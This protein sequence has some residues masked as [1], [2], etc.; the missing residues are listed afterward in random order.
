MVKIIFIADPLPSLYSA[1]SHCSVILLLFGMLVVVATFAD[2][3]T[4]YHRKACEQTLEPKVGD[5][6]VNVAFET[7]L[8]GSKDHAADS[9]QQK[10]SANRD[11]TKLQFSVDVI[12]ENGSIAELDKHTYTLAKESHVKGTG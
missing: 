2:W 10:E 5:G 4:T 9:V 11:S 6:Q 1:H 8:H 3:L 12:G 7:D